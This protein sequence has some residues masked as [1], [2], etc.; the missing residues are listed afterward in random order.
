[1]TRFV[2]IRRDTAGE[3]HIRFLDQLMT[4][5]PADSDRAECLWDALPG[6][7]HHGLEEGEVAAVVDFDL[8][9]FAFFR[10]EKREI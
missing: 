9:R 7:M 4:N 1:M 10:G 2:A 3:F 6:I 5:A 8:D